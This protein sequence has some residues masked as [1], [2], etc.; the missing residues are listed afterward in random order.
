MSKHFLSIIKSPILHFLILGLAAFFLYEKFRPVDRDVINITTQ[1]IDA[2]VQQRENIDRNPVTPEL[3]EQIIKGHI[4]DE[5]LLREAQKR[6]FDNNDYRVRKRLLR[7]MRSS[8]TEV[9][10]EPSIAQLRA[11]Y[12]E[13]IE[14]YKTSPSVSFEYVFFDF[15]S[16]DMPTDPQEFIRQLEESDDPL[17]MGEFTPLGK[18]FVKNHF[19]MIASSFGKPFAEKVFDMDL[20]KWTG[21]VESFRGIHYVRVTAHHDPEVPSF[22]NLESYLRQDYLMQKMRQ[23]QQ[24]K[25]DELRKGYVVVVEGEEM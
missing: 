12:D 7:V 8:L 3:R 19:Q 25:I 6:G 5:V 10:P 17:K 22:E 14:L 1:T 21:P 2:L 24:G 20:N 18:R 16:T 9:V 4:D 13:N 11:Y 23:N 15:S